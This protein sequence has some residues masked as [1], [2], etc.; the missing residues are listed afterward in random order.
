MLNTEEWQRKKE[1]AKNVAIEVT[2]EDI[3]DYMEKCNDME[4]N[5][6]DDDSEDSHGPYS[7]K[8]SYGNHDDMHQMSFIKRFG[9]AMTYNYSLDY[10]FIIQA[11]GTC[12][13]PCSRKVS[14][15]WMD[16]FQIDIPD[17]CSDTCKKGVFKTP[18]ALMDHLNTVGDLDKNNGFLHRFVASYSKQ[19]YKD[20]FFPKKKNK[21]KTGQHQSTKWRTNRNIVLATERP[22]YDSRYEDPSYQELPPATERPY[23]DCR[24]EDE[25]PFY[26][27]LPPHSYHLQSRMFSNHLDD[28]WKKREKEVAGKKKAEEGEGNKTGVEFSGTPVMKTAM[29]EGIKTGV[30]FKEGSRSGAP[31]MKTP[32]GVAMEESSAPSL[33]VAESS[34]SSTTAA[35]AK[36]APQDPAMKK[37]SFQQSCNLQENLF[38]REQQNKDLQVIQIQN[39]TEELNP[40]KTNLEVYVQERAVASAESAVENPATKTATGVAIPTGKEAEDEDKEERQQLKQVERPEQATAEKIA[41]EEAVTWK[42]D[43]RKNV[44]TTETRNLTKKKSQEENV[45]GRTSTSGGGTVGSIITLSSDIDSSAETVT[46]PTT[47]TPTPEKATNIKPA[48]VIAD[49]LSL[50]PKDINRDLDSDK[51]IKVDDISVP[52][53]VFHTIAEHDSNF[54]KY[55][56]NR[57]KRSSTPEFNHLLKNNNDRNRVHLVIYDN[58]CDGGEIITNKQKQEITMES[59]RRLI[60]GQCLNDEIINNFFQLLAI[61]D[62]QQ[63]QAKTSLFFPTTFMYLLLDKEP[64]KKYTFANVEGWFMRNHSDMIKDTKKIFI[65]INISRLHWALVVIFFETK[66]INYYDS[67]RQDG[68]K[69]VEATIQF[70]IELFENNVTYSFDVNEWEV[71]FN[72]RGTPIQWNGTDCGAFVC[73]YA[74]YT[75]LDLVLPKQSLEDMILYREGIADALLK[76]RVQPPPTKAEVATKTA[77]GVAMAASATPAAQHPGIKTATGAVTMAESSAPSTT[78]ASNQHEVEKENRH[79]EEEDDDELDRTVMEHIQEIIKDSSRGS[80]LKGRL[81]TCL[82]LFETNE[83]YD[84]EGYEEYNGKHTSFYIYFHTY[85]IL[86]IILL[87]NSSLDKFLKSLVQKLQGSMSKAKKP[88]DRRKKL[89]K[90]VESFLKSPSLYVLWNTYQLDKALFDRGLHAHGTKQV[91][92]QCLC[93]NDSKN[94][95]K[96]VARDSTTKT[97]SGR[98]DVG[99]GVS[100]TA[101]SPTG[102]N[103]DDVEKQGPPVPTEPIINN[104]NNTFCL[105]PIRNK[106]KEKQKVGEKKEGEDEDKEERQQLE[107]GER[108]EQATAEKIAAE[109]AITFK[110]DVHIPKDATTTATTTTRGKTSVIVA[111][112]ERGEKREKLAEAEAAENLV[113]DT[114]ASTSGASTSH[115]AESSTMILSSDNNSRNKDVDGSTTITTT[116]QILLPPITEKDTWD[117]KLGLKFKDLN[118]KVLLYSFSDENYIFD[119][120][121]LSIGDELLEIDGKPVHSPGEAKKM[122]RDIV[123]PVYQH[124]KVCLGKKEAPDTKTLILT[125]KS[126]CTIQQQL[127]RTLQDI[128]TTVHSLKQ[129]KHVLYMKSFLL[130][131]NIY[132]YYLCVDENGNPVKQLNHQDQYY[133]TGSLKDHYFALDCAKKFNR[134]SLYKKYFETINDMQ[135]KNPVLKNIKPSTIYTY[136]NRLIQCY[137]EYN[138]DNAI[139]EKKSWKHFTSPNMYPTYIEKKYVLGKRV[140]NSQK[141]SSFKSSKFVESTLSAPFNSPH[142]LKSSFSVLSDQSSISTDFANSQDSNKSSF[143]VLSD[144]SSISSD[145]ANSLDSNIE[146]QVMEDEQND[147]NT[148][149]SDE[150]CISS[151]FDN[152]QDSN[153]EQQVTEDEQN[154]DN[155]AT[156]L[157]EIESEGQ[158]IV[159][160][161]YPPP[162]NGHYNWDGLLHID[163]RQKQHGNKI[164]VEVAEMDKEIYDRSFDRSVFEVDDEGRLEVGDI[165]TKVNGGNIDRF[166]YNELITHIGDL[167]S[168]LTEFPEDGQLV[169][170]F[171]KG[172]DDDDMSSNDA[173]NNSDDSKVMDNELVSLPPR[174]RMKTG[175]RP[176]DN[177]LEPQFFTKSAKTSR[178]RN[179]TK[180][181]EISL[182]SE[183]KE[184]KQTKKPRQKFV[185]DYGVEKATTRQEV[186]VAN[187]DV[188]DDPYMGYG[189]IVKGR[190]LEKYSL[191]VDGFTIVP[192]TM[193]YVDGFDGFNRFPF[194]FVMQHLHDCEDPHKVNQTTD[195]WDVL[196]NGENDDVTKEVTGRWMSYN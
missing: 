79:N 2:N 142:S 75:S 6:D 109:E 147:D 22:H 116:V 71:N 175:P 138:K 34:A 161:C 113:T 173:N 36:P 84:E 100:S 146:E 85:S 66:N 137:K 150:S 33:A 182:G 172:N 125:F 192:N 111:E 29:G 187:I 19:L 62:Q 10:A 87:L 129:H 191:S 190:D 185:M 95:P 140:E 189:T 141:K 178:K 110:V 196:F 1:Q 88:A 47:E 119:H 96:N 114:T 160:V 162:T 45:G 18:Q 48:I 167:M 39:Y 58:K 65:P 72:P 64:S 118:N 4:D 37:I 108:P 90:D 56:R 55:V 31:V 68:R 101:G 32:T 49:V 134:I 73:L 165:L 179:N 81:L 169:L 93:D 50:I 136:Y 61:R 17:G 16:I 123:A 52:K 102:S 54:Y 21:K 46:S 74:D 149:L 152:S 115:V 139:V 155:N 184:T 70:L 30:E 103:Q 89:L 135:T 80:F 180:P 9:E 153:I 164:L 120:I 59:M 7:D 117:G 145:F 193:L 35:S 20:V 171:K 112:Q 86:I 131:K 156:I 157:N 127:L 122:I 168:E 14:S 132:Q 130:L 151:D 15:N 176:Y 143:S 106:E 144:Q 44:T 159:N 98:E 11:N 41:A 82:Y 99:G 83:S 126:S 5:S 195:M 67:L 177:V 107:K 154:D 40:S 38:Y 97:K 163:L 3:T 166:Q 94:S 133:D 92:V 60:P 105:Y 121:D 28:N 183:T 76:G 170:T 91:K 26:Q 69:F 174:K 53:K 12:C 42:E 57:V 158:V 181:K 124:Y 128:S 186:I 194:Q 23:H 148:A 188:L 8:E 24:Y 78:S 13:C 25:D 27:E 77:T 43:T 63:G 104:I 51:C